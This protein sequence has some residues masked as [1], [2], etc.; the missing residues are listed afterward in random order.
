MYRFPGLP[1][2]QFCKYIDAGREAV[3]LKNIE[4]E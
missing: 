1:S 2:I 4:I 3:D